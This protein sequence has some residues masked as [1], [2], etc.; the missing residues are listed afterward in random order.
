MHTKVP[1]K[2]HG[3]TESYFRTQNLYKLCHCQHY[4]SRQLALSFSRAI[5]PHPYSTERPGQGGPPITQYFLV[6]SHT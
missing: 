3:P 2:Q 1:K 5:I 6:H 4:E